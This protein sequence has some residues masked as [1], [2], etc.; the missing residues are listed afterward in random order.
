M[1]RTGAVREA[2]YTRVHVDIVR[3]G[4][5]VI[6]ILTSGMYISPITVYREYVQNAA[7]AI[8]VARSQGLLPKTAVGRITINIDHADRTVGIRD[9]GI[10]IPSRYAVS[11]LM[12]IGASPKRGTTARGFRGV[13]RLSGLAYCRELEF[14]SK[15]AGERVIVSALWDCRALRARISDSAFDG[16]LQRIVSDV[17]IVRREST[18]DDDDHFFEVKMKGVTRTRNDELLNESLVRHY[19]S[20]V[21]PVRFHPDFSYAR[22]IEKHISAP[23]ARSSVQLTVAGTP[24]ERPYRDVIDLPGSSR[25]IR[26]HS[27]ELIELPDV[28][29]GVGAV[30]WL[31]HHEY[32]RSIPYALGIRGLR[33]RVGDLQVGGSDIFEECFKE[34]RFNSWTVGEICILDRRIVPNARR[35]NFELNHH[36]Y[37]FLVQLGPL[38]ARIAQRCR[39]SSIARNAAERVRKVIA[40]VDAK[41]RERRRL[42]RAELSRLKSTLLRARNV[43]KRVE[44]VKLQNRFNRKLDKLEAA[45]TKNRLKKGSSVLAFDEVAALISRVVT[46]REQARR[47]AEELRRMSA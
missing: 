6:E 3:I 13:G 16:D 9:N 15:A 43:L 28:D 32:V 8:D 7:D 41:T 17:V 19:L 1:E 2:E 27:I 14:R 24:V 31:G 26:I 30:G 18:R 10:G 40:E 34:P 29:G 37:N 47:L 44:D 42:D 21:A 12:S 46:N 20:Q 36:Y 22:Q 33:A 25:A 35:D 38:A 5:D 39:S 23:A 45:L 11:T 4:K